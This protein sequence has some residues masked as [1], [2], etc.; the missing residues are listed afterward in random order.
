MSLVSDMAS[1][2]E[3]DV[4]TESAVK[5]TENCLVI[6]GWEDGIHDVPLHASGLKWYNVDNDEQYAYQGSIWKYLPATAAA[7]DLTWD[8]YAEYE[9]EFDEAVASVVNT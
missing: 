9:V 2:S 3:V 8:C 7:G 1:T 4:T 6:K 5:N